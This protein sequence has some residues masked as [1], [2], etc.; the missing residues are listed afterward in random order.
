MWLFHGIERFFFYYL[1][2]LVSCADRCG[3]ASKTHMT[4]ARWNV[5]V[6]YSIPAQDMDMYGRCIS[7]LRWNK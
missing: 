3:R 6:A 1:I 5:V 2:V 4:F 7:L